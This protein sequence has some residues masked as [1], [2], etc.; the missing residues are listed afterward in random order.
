MPQDLTGLF[1][2]ALIGQSLSKQMGVQSAVGGDI[3]QT[4]R[5][6]TLA[7]GVATGAIKPQSLS[8]SDAG[9]LSTA[10]TVPKVP[11]GGGS[12]LGDIFG[13]PLK[14]VT[15][16]AGDLV[17]AAESLPAG[18]EQLGQSTAKTFAGSTFGHA[19]GLSQNDISGPDLYG[20]GGDIVKS[21]VHDFTHF[22]PMHPLYPALD[23]AAIASAG[24]SAL[25]RGGGALARLA[26]GGD[27]SRIASLV[28]RGTAEKLGDVGQ[29]LA[30][31]FGN[32]D[33][34]PA[35]IT[36][37][38]APAG[39][40]IPQL[41]I[42]EHSISPFRRLFVE[43]PIDKLFGTRVA[44]LD[45]P[46]LPEGTSAVDLRGAYQ[47]RKAWNVLRGRASSESI[48]QAGLATQGFNRAMQGLIDTSVNDTQALEKFNALV[49]M[50]ELGAEN[51]TPAERFDVLEEYRNKV[52]APATNIEGVALTPQVKAIRE[53]NRKLTSSPDYIKY[54]T[55]PDEAMM[56]VRDAWDKAILSGHKALNEAGMGIDPNTILERALGPAAHIRNMTPEELLREQPENVQRSM[57][58]A[59]TA[60][61]IEQALKE[62]KGASVNEEALIPQTAAQLPGNDLTKKIRLVTDA[63]ESL[64]ADIAGE[65][66]PRELLNNAHA[67]GYLPGNNLAQ[68]VAAELPTRLGVAP[69]VAEPFA[70]G[71]LTNY[72]PQASAHPTMRVRPNGGPVAR[73]M[74]KLISAATRGQIK[75]ES[76]VV[77][78]HEV[79]RENL[80]RLLD[81]NSIGVGPFASFMQDAD[82]TAFKAGIDRRDPVVMARH[83]AQREK[84]L[85]HRWLA[86]PFI[87]KIAVKDDAG[88]LIQ[89]ANDAE[90]EQV[91]GDS[92]I[93]AKYSIISPRA[94]QVLVQTE[95]KGALDVAKALG[96]TGGKMTEEL[97]AHIDRIA[98]EGAIMSVRQLADE[99]IA[100][101]GKG[102]LVPNSYYQNLI[103]H[104]KVLDNSS[105]VGNVWRGFINKWRSAVLAYMPSWLLRTS[106]G[107]GFILFL[108]GVWDPRH[109]MAAMKNFDLEGAGAKDLV[110]LPPGIHQGMP[111]S[112]FGQIGQRQYAKNM[113]APAITGAV[114]RVANFQRRAGFIS[115]LNRVVKQHFAELGEAFELPGGLRN[116]TNLQK[117]IDEHPEWV[118]H[119]LNE[120]DRVSYTFG[121]MSPWER[122]LAKNI[123]PF[124]GWYRFVSKFVWSLPITY[125]GRALAITR[126]GQIGAS[127]QNALGPMP[128]WLR[129]SIMF[130]THNLSQVHYMSML[131]L[132]PL[133]DVANPAAGIQGLVRL[134]Q[135]SPV[136]QA[137]L[138]GAGYN[139]LTG[140]LESMDP[141]LGIVEVNGK[142]VN[143]HTGQEVDSPGQASVGSS[144]E[145][146]IG[147][148]A[149]SFPEARIGELAVT[150]GYPVYP[151]SIPIL[152]ERRI[153]T[154]NTKDVS[155]P[156]ILAQYAGVAP[157]TYDLAKYQQ[158]LLKDIKR[159]IS[160]ARKAQIKER[161]L[162]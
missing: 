151:E 1:R 112:E 77:G 15:N 46:G 3:G 10:I 56:T 86:E 150:G 38:E 50:R 120:L 54:F 16:T 91:F 136:I 101:R 131:G 52:F 134:G 7:R 107:H 4:F 144:L 78:L 70:S 63:V 98:A 23:L 8:P 21:T 42:P 68:K 67:T 96:G 126:L 19:L 72:F 103:K 95:D 132:N 82:L 32:L 125:P 51:M 28:G 58:F 26:E 39:V 64:R 127:D 111:H 27:A 149:R 108:S 160:T 6:L 55:E 76:G 17:G 157:K 97:M 81:P 14:I 122:R 74:D 31:K 62:S 25:A 143:I 130:D 73:K 85:V 49:L 89:V 105:R 43:K 47:T 137:A 162:P 128:D 45:I 69:E 155:I 156:G 147:G 22:D 75:R 11:S 40:K 80:S 44:Q 24:T 123:I 90:K 146:M 154:T 37:G 159:A 141:A 36:S 66:T 138:E 79:R 133:G 83:I 99:A 145:R 109:Y 5:A 12:I 33:R 106:V 94:L 153:P 60:H 114:H 2:G 113:L 140:G 61:E 119:A 65:H 20:L 135:M 139:T 102:I 117:V 53:F 59:R 118:H 29:K 41:P 152:W 100:S 142:Y 84:V 161:A 71:G 158:N 129:A 93:A 18:I 115:M 88:N 34:A 124:W 92:N 148:L 35:P 9:L 13:T 57:N 121:Q 110:T 30:F 87:A 116:A 104:A 48:R